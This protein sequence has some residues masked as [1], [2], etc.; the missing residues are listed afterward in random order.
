MVTS[1]AG[2]FRPAWGDEK[3]GQLCFF[4]EPPPRQGPAEGHGGAR[5]RPRGR[6][7]LVGT[8]ETPEVGIERNRRVQPHAAIRPS[9]GSRGTITTAGRPRASGARKPRALPRARTS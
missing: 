9:V 1:V 4:A 5:P 3:M 8:V 6:P 2:L 7:S